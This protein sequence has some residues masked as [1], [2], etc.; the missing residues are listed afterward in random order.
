M[1][2][3][4]TAIT[5]LPMAENLA[6]LLRRP[7][8]L[9]SP[10][11]FDIVGVVRVCFDMQQQTDIVIAIATTAMKAKTIATIVLVLL[12]LS[13]WAGDVVSADGIS[14][15]EKGLTDLTSQLLH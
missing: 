12:L 11:V 2:S 7:R 15:Q 10:F 1:A 6:H 8:G 5:K 13:L 14:V 3:E 9:G 4:I